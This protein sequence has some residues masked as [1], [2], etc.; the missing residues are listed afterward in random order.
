MD[1]NRE[2]NPE[3]VALLKKALTC[4]GTQLHPLVA[5]ADAEVLR[6]ALKN[7]ALGPEHMQAILQRRDLDASILTLLCRHGLSR[8]RE[9]A[10]PLLSHPHINPQQIK[11]VLDKL[12]L[13]ELLNIA[14]LPGQATDVRIAAEH[15][16]CARLPTTA[17]G[18]KITLARRATYPVLEALMREG[19][20]HLIEPCL[21]NPRMKE[22]ALNKFL[23]GQNIC[24]ASINAIARHPRWNKRPNIRRAILS[25]RHSSKQ[26]FAQFLPGLPVEQARQ[27]L[28]SKHLQHSQK[29]WI[30]DILALISTR[31]G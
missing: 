17:L 12:H 23:H 27:L 18:T 16:I 22:V 5:R 14:I 7:V 25:N 8:S 20:P 21:N 19:D 10:R 28:Y 13:L 1:S 2:F 31:K 11:T 30:R 24:A 9:V 26:L 4:S 3:R 15:N 6:A 29:E